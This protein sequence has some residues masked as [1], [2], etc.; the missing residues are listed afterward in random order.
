MKPKI[1]T[2][3][4]I[5]IVLCWSIAFIFALVSAKTTSEVKEGNLLVNEPGKN[6]S[7]FISSN[8]KTDTNEVISPILKA[9]FPF[10]ALYVKMEDPSL[11]QNT[12]DFQ[13]YMR[14][15]NENWT[16]W[17]QTALDD[18]SQGKDSSL[19]VLM[20]QMI[21]TKLTDSFQYKLIFNNKTAKDSLKNLQFIYLDTTKGPSGNFRISTQNN[22]DDLH[23]I[24]RAEWGANE[25]YRYDANGQDLWPEEYY[26]PQKFVIHHTAGEKANVDPKSTI[27][28]I[29]YYHAKVRGWGDIGYNYLIDSKG[30]IY[31]GRAGGEGTVGGHAYLRNRNTIGIAILGCYD[32]AL[33]SKNKPD[34]N[35]PDNLTEATKIALDKLIAKKSQE[36]NIDPLATSEFHGQILPNVLGHRDVGSTTCPGNLIYDQLPQTRQLAYN[37]L[38]DYGGYQKPLPSAAEFV[39]L[40]AKDL[41]IEETKTADV[42]VEFKNIGQAVWRGYE[43]NYVYISDASLKN[44]LTKIDS[45]KIA[46]TSDKDGEL[47]NQTSSQTVFK[48][49]GGNVY[50]GEIGKFKLVLNPPQDKKTETKNFTLAWQN[51]GYFPN[52]D[53]SIA[54]NKIACQTCNQNTNPV[55][56]TYNATLSQSNLAQ[57]MA[58][59]SM[60]TVNLQF[61]NTGNV[62]WNKSKLKLKIVYEKTN[63]SPF[64]NDSWHTEWADIPPQE[65]I[66]YPNSSANFE[67]KL[68]APNVL[69]TFPHTLT[70]NYDDN[71]IYQLDQIIEVTSPYAAQITVNTLPQTAKPNS[72]P[73]VT[74]TFKNTGTKTWT[75]LAL[76]SYDLDYTNS[77]FKDWSWLDSKTVKKIK[78]TVSPGEDI[79]FSFR[80]LAYW[81]QNTYPQLFKLMDGKN[82]IY[83]DGKKELIAYTKVAK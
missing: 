42:Y 22:N 54:L 15:L 34:C 66:I 28:A 7:F 25:S 23:I 77:W 76:K 71:Q 63:I 14:F 1:R 8:N 21:P 74:I 20:S 10:N 27:R 12:Q 38:Q 19:P 69:A 59:G 57:Q 37:L 60:A 58:S 31:E 56:E 50:P 62:A 61:K 9:D 83:L 67:F 64:R 80:L 36:F 68:K 3:L 53:F 49:L 78:T 30:N 47:A 55:A 4:V 2:K 41:N 46:L 24:S 6:G 32:T 79:T 81:K 73:K 48:L 33:N 82:E 65:T 72:R 13:L 43:D 18:D 45:V 29:Q 40:S 11:S 51:K 17:F 70:L 5:F 16:E 44:K 26:T 75:N 35:T 39:S 52:T